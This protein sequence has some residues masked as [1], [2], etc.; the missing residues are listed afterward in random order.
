MVGKLVAHP[1]AN[2]IAQPKSFQQG[3][4]GQIFMAKRKDTNDIVAIKVIDINKPEF[5]KV[6]LNEVAILTTMKNSIYS[7]KMI[8]SFEYNN[9]GY[10]VM[11]LLQEDLYT[12]SESFNSI[13][14]IKNIF[15]QIC[16]GVK[17]LHENGVAHLD[18]KPENILL[19]HDDEVKICD[20]G[21]SFYCKES[22]IPCTK[23]VG[24]DY[25]IAP[26]VLLHEFGYSAKVADIWS[27][28][29]ILCMMITGTYPY[30]GRNENEC[31]Q[32]YFACNVSLNELQITLP[33]DSLC[34]DLVSRLLCKSPVSR[35]TIDEILKHPWLDNVHDESEWTMEM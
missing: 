29:I 27:L 21:G 24:S 33:N 18:L 14:E 12:R 34:F 6:Y 9:R 2:Y 26:E 25:Y 32:N 5:K 4:T 28:G 15:V 8:E 19:Q 23:F 31:L 22:D 35:I 11:E 10:I 30:C 7:T 17:E 16:K 3:G 1:I 13:E 20:F